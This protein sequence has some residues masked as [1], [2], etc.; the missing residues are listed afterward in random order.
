M[1]LG[2]PEQLNRGKMENILSITFVRDICDTITDVA[3]LGKVSWNNIKLIYWNGYVDAMRYFILFCLRSSKDAN[4][5]YMS[6]FKQID[7]NAIANLCE[8]FT[9]Q[10]HISVTIWT[11][12]TFFTANSLLK[13]IGWMIA[14]LTRCKTKILSSQLNILVYLIVL[15]ISRILISF[16]V[17]NYCFI[18]S[19]SIQLPLHRFITICPTLTPQLA[20]RVQLIYFRIVLWNMQVRWRKKKSLAS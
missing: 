14:S 19:V 2:N 4:K 9:I 5:T 10:E 7:N 17:A 13:G 11:Q 16:S 18:T 1:A 12:S 15:L 3:R 20:F 6:N 8:Q